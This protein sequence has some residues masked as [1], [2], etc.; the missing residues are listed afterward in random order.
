MD[1][2]N[3]FNPERNQDSQGGLKHS[4]TIQ[5]ISSQPVIAELDIQNIHPFRQ[6]P[7]YN[8]PTISPHPI[9][10]ISPTSYSCIDGW[11]LIQDAVSTGNSKITCH[12]FY[13]SEH[14]ET[15]IAIRKVAIRTMPQGGTCS[16]AE[17][18]RNAGIVFKMLM[19]TTENPVLFS[20]GGSRKGVSYTDSKEKNIRSTMIDRLGKSQIT[21]NKYLQHGEYLNDDAL[22]ALVDADAPK[23]FFEAI[24]KSKQS[25][26][27]ELESGKTSPEEIIRQVSEKVLDWFKASQ[28][29]VT[30]EISSVV[31]PNVKQPPAGTDPGSS[32]QRTI[33][34]KFRDP[35]PW[36]ESDPGAE[37]EPFSEVQVR[38]EIGN[39]AAELMR[40]AQ[41]GELTR[42]KQIEIVRGQ[43][44][45]LARLLQH[46]S[47][48]SEKEISEKE[49]QN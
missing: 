1:R 3:A 4:Q 18:V 6:I 7:D 38:Q 17:L 27:S 37:T 30:E 45:A 47:L 48:Q 29:T 25:V 43:I 22:Q 23:G 26:A 36:V 33:A 35:E 39:V 44:A 49:V 2:P 34:Q 8:C 24:Q 20:H 41:G 9:V 31:F 14:F 15:E 21:I 11:N 13:I 32:G 42:E 40:I 28:I 12:A 16:Y 10:V 5:S 19:E 46:L